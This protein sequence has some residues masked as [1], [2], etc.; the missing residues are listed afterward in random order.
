MRTF[1]CLPQ[2]LVACPF[3]RIDLLPY[4]IVAGLARG[5]A[6]ACGQAEQANGICRQL[7]PAFTVTKE[8][9][10]RGPVNKGSRGNFGTA[11]AL[12]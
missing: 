4:A 7:S 10:N 11:C 2:E 9:W 1:V 6:D 8:K 5:A 3:W 12:Q